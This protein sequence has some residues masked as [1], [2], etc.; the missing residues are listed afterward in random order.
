MLGTPKARKLTSGNLCCSRRF[1]RRHQRC[2]PERAERVESRRDATKWRGLAAGV[3]R[4]FDISALVRP[5]L[6]RTPCSTTG[7]TERDGLSFALWVYSLPVSLAPHRPS[8]RVTRI[9]GVLLRMGMRCGTKA[10]PLRGRWAACRS[11]EVFPSAEGVIIY[12]RNK[13]KI[14]CKEI[15]SLA[16]DYTSSVAEWRHLPL[17]GKAFRRHRRGASVRQENERLAPPASDGGQSGRPVPT[18]TLSAR[19]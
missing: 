10:F 16:S 15:T 12:R 2:H 14:E 6:R 17:K 3:M 11:D 13:D 8:L 7:V 9:L 4:Q 1:R 19:G 5:R 18:V